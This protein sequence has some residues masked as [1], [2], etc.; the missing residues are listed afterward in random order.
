MSRRVKDVT[1]AWGVINVQGP[2]SRNFL[3]PLIP[4]LENLKFSRS[5]DVSLGGVDVTV[6]RLTYVGE[7]GYEIHAPRDTC[8]HVLDTLLSAGPR[9]KFAGTEAMESLA[10]EAGYR[11]WPADISQVFHELSMLDDR[12]SHFTQ[13]DTPLEA[14]MGWVCSKTKQ[15]RGRQKMME[16]QRSPGHKKLISLALDPEALVVGSEP[17]VCDGAVVGYVRRAETG[18]LANVEQNK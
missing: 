5:V 10:V 11:H 6:Y 14:G 12:V 17:M 18:Q 13:I 1:Q 7:L 3:K 8:G 9:I 16:R 15:F 2:Q 4:E